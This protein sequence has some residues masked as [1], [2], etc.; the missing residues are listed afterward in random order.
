M[1]VVSL[2]FPLDHHRESIT[3]HVCM[4]FP[5][6]HWITIGSLSCM[7]MVSPYSH[8]FTI[9]SLAGDQCEMMW[10]EDLCKGS[11]EAHTFGASPSRCF[12][13]W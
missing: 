3:D 6:S 2:S 9:G 8:W 1:Y 12:L 11:I 4:L 10:N 5:Y 7:Y 13:S